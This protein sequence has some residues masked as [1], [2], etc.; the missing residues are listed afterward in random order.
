MVCEDSTLLPAACVLEQ[1]ETHLGLG[2]NIKKT[3]SVEELERPLR[4]TKLS[5]VI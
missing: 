3:A 1:Q 5:E 2:V 4:Q